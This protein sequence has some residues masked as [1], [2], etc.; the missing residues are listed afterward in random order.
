ML[1]TY[2]FNTPH[3]VQLTLYCKKTNFKIKFNLPCTP[4]G[5]NSIAVCLHEFIVHI[6][7]EEQ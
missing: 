1:G 5:V 3:D 2:V 6:D 7:Q 4:V